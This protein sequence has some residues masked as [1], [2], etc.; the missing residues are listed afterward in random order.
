LRLKERVLDSQIIWTDDTPVDLQDRNHEENIVEAR[1]W[2]Y[3]GDRNNDFTVFDFTDS[4]KRDGPVNFLKDF[5]GFLQAD[6]YAGYDHVYAGK[7]VR[8]VACWAHARRKF[9]D[10]IGSSKKKAN[11]VLRHIQALYR[12]EKRC[13]NETSERRQYLRQRFSR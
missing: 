11:H 7:N 5:K 8:E 1:I 4:H 13:A 10:A 2:T 6:A 9:F 12:I 3:I